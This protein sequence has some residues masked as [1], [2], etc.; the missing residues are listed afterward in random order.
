MSA[1]IS[2]GAVPPAIKLTHLLNVDL[3]KQPPGNSASL[4]QEREQDVL[5]RDLGC[6]EPIGM[7]PSAE[8]HHVESV[9]L[10]G[11]RWIGHD[12]SSG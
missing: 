11:Q 6:A 3:H 9:E 4:V 8:Q 2:P 7:H 1:F 10:E 5:C 12:L